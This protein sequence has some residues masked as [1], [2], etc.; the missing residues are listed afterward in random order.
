MH[1]TR[2]EG[3]LL[4]AAM[5]G[6]FAAAVEA[7]T[8]A[9]LELLDSELRHDHMQAWRITG[10]AAG[11]VVTQTAFVRGT[12]TTALW[13]LYIAGR[14]LRPARQMMREI[15]DELI[16]IASAWGCMEIRVEGKRALQWLRV[17]PDFEII[18]RRGAE[19]VLR[20]VL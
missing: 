3:P 15:G 17:L 12:E 11:Y 6:I 2:L 18:E 13:V 20:K 19:T 1:L 4:T 10:G 8:S 9:D 7:D 5:P 14:C 16:K